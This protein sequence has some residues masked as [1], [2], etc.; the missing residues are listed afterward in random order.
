MKRITK[1][2]L[3]VIAVSAGFQLLGLLGSRLFG[4][5]T[6]E[7][8]EDFRVGAFWGGRRFSSRSRLLCSGSALAVL[9]GVD[10]D[11]TGA[12]PHPAGLDLSLRVYA[13]GMKLSLN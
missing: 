7:E 8:S 12:T 5:G 13:G 11:L 6:D 10:L 4:R 2:V 3:S 1:L 9:G